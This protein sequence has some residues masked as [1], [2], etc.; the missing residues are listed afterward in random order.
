MTTGIIGAVGLL[1]RDW[2]IVKITKRV[3][4]DN[5]LKIEEYKT[6]LLLEYSKSM[7]VMRHDFSR[8][9]SKREVLHKSVFECSAIYQKEKMSHSLKLWNLMIRI[10]TSLPYCVQFLDVITLDE[11]ETFFENAQ[12]KMNL[13]IGDDFFDNNFR[14]SSFEEARLFVGSYIWTLFFVYRAVHFR[15]VYLFKSGYEKRLLQP[16]FGN[17][18]S[19]NLLKIVLND[20]E[21]LEFDELKFGK[22]GWFERVV[23]DKMI[24]AVEDVA[25][26]KDVREITV[27]EM[28]SIERLVTLMNTEYDNN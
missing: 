23:E 21:Y 11:Y 3:E 16:W 22:L 25:T 5:S 7:E 14:D 15:A 27:G 8:E 20:V 28:L 18:Y 1:M 24:R 10:R 17:P 12:R 4:Y 2:I 26:G 19:I 9:M 6:S 13:S